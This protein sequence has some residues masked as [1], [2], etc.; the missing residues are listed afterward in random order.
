MDALAPSSPYTPVGAG[1]TSVTGNP[2]VLGS[3]VPGTTSGLPALSGLSVLQN[4]MA[5]ALRSKGR[6]EDSMLV[7]MTPDEVNSLQ[8]LAMAAGGSLTI[9]PE[10]GLPEAGWLG[11]LLPTILGGVLAATGVGAPL[12]AG[13]VGL[14]QTAITGDLKKGLMAGLGAFG[15]ASLAGAAGLGGEI[16]KNAFGALGD[17]A[18]IF[19][20]NMGAG[21]GAVSGLSGATQETLRNAA[22]QGTQGAANEG[23]KAAMT[24]ALSKV[25]NAAGAFANTAGA[26]QN[27]T[28]ATSFFGKFGEAA[29]AGLPG[30]II[31]KAAPMLAAQGVLGS[32]SNAMTPTVKSAE[33]QT[34]NSYQ[35]P[36]YSPQRKIVANVTTEDILAGNGGQRRWFDVGMP[37]VRNTMGQLVQPGSGTAPGTPILQ[38]VLS[39]DIVKK[40][41]L[42]I[43]TKTVKDANKYTQQWVPFM[44][45][46][47]TG[48]AE[49]GEVK[50]AD[51]AFVMPARE[52]TEF[53]KG[54]TK[55][56]DI[57]A[58]YG[59]IPIKGPGDGV[60]DSIP[61]R[62]GGKQEARVADGEVYFPP[63]AVKRIGGG[64]QQR[65]TQKLYALMRKAEKSRRTTPRGGKGLDLLKDLT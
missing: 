49:G 2:P 65:G 23:T 43:G 59:G 46:Q 24:Q 39:P 3:Q 7:H 16:S 35:G 30:G 37:E 61:A 38:N 10:T 17:K 18:G 13:I 11:K 63:E 6:G 62:I 47:D 9:N 5:E 4:P 12:A 42:G 26:I 64:D 27:A 36:Y 21:A 31:G 8:G 25:P 48:Y 1:P 19:G 57:L 15:G 32:V 34:D 53:A 60:S 29:R 14:G 22:M 52:T 20:S 56:Q 51:G 45:E 58:E 50:L 40:G 33:Q 41:F 55:G 28:P 54:G 44:G